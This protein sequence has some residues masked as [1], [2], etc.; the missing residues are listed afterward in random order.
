MTKNLICVALIAML[1]GAAADAEAQK[2]YRWVDKDGKVHYSDKVPPSEVDQARQELNTQGRTV[3]SVDRALT[4]EEQAAADRAAQEAEV[5]RKAKEAQDRMDQMLLSS[6]DQESDLKRAYDER[7]DLLDQSIVSAETGIKSQERSLADILAH[8]AEL[9]R[10]GKPVGDSVKA[11]IDLSR[12]Q[13][14]QQNE[15]LKKRQDER[16]ALEQEFAETVARYRELKAK[17]AE[18]KSQGE[19]GS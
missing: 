5:A 18:A 4:P 11:S 1:A 16:A 3:D 6:Y 14:Q 8:A 13:V 19:R 9:E 17:Q 7:F 12:R 15:Y 2:L 10:S